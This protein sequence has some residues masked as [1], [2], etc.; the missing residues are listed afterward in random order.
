[1]CSKCKKHMR[2]AHT[3]TLEES[4]QLEAFVYGKCLSGLSSREKE[5]REALKIRGQQ[6]ATI[7]GA[8]RTNSLGHEMFVTGPIRWCLRCGG[9]ACNKP[10]L[11]SG[12]C[13]GKVKAPAAVRRLQRGLH[14]ATGEWL[15]VAQRQ[16]Q[17]LQQ[18]QPA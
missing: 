8:A 18:Q 6:Q 1:M 2:L 4:T 12:P 10:Q 15:G 7:G 9:Y 13:A 3:P 16:Q 14:P 5:R 17:Q 11:L